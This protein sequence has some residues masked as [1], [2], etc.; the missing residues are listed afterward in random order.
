TN[1]PGSVAQIQLLSGSGQSAVVGT[2]FANP[3]N[4]AVVDLFGNIV[5]GVP[6][7]FTVPSSGPSATLSATSAI[8]NALGDANVTATANSI[9][10]SY[11][12]TA[13]LLGIPLVSFQLTNLPGGAG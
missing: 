5:V 3:L 4:V 13:S 7:T 8:T 6:V 12:V 11:T 2:M 9:A 10:G 1:T